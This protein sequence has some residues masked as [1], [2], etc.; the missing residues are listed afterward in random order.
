M[1]YKNQ[2]EIKEDEENPVVEASPQV[3]WPGI[4]WV[5]ESQSGQVDWLATF[6]FLK[7]PIIE[8]IPD[9]T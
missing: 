4:G 7:Y 6:L 5:V 1:K 3:Y 9:E 8:E 2:Q